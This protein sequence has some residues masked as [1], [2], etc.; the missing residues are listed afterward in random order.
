MSGDF[1]TDCTI[2]SAVF[3]LSTYHD[4]SNRKLIPPFRHLAFLFMSLRFSPPP[5][6]KVPYHGGAV[7]IDTIHFVIFQL[8]CSVKLTPPKNISFILQYL[9]LLLTPFSFLIKAL[10]LFFFFRKFP[11]I[12]TPPHTGCESINFNMVDYT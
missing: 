8:K 12:P 9:S 4:F 7:T 10:I 3:A 1:N 2:A 11:V 5:N 6:K